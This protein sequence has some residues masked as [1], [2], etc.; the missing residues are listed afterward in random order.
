ML[1]RFLE[2]EVNAVTD[3]S[4]MSSVS[5]DEVL[6]RAKTYT[7]FAIHI[8]NNVIKYEILVDV[9]SYTMT[10]PSHLFEVLDSRLSRY[11]C[12]GK[13]LTGDNE[14]SIFISFKE[15]VG[16]ENRF[17]YYNLV[18]GRLREVTLFE[19]YKRLM[20]LEFRKSEVEAT[21]V[22]KSDAILAC[23]KCE[24]IWEVQMPDFEMCKC[25]RCG[26]VLLN[27]ICTSLEHR[28]E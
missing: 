11:F 8:R 3:W 27:P 24:N 16:I 4:R 9:D 19:H 17:F 12:L 1:V 10:F 5:K 20:E 23:P 26:T 13:S 28:S 21:A 6:L 7:V 15:W 14:E 25:D 2:H 22:L 18:E